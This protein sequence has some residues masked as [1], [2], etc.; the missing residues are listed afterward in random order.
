MRD[1]VLSRITEISALLNS[2][3][4][5]IGKVFRT[6]KPSG[7]QWIM[8]NLFHKIDAGEA[9]SGGRQSAPGSRCGRRCQPDPA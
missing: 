5:L 6:R 1:E 8:P 9:D 4:C 2:D 7:K 3:A